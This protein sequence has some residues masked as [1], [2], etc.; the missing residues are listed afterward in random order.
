[1]LIWLYLLLLDLY[2]HLPGTWLY[3]HQNRSWLWAGAM[4][5]IFQLHLWTTSIVE[6]LLICTVRHYVGE[7]LSF[8]YM[9]IGRNLHKTLKGISCRKLMPSKTILN[10]KCSNLLPEKQYAILL[11][12]HI[13]NT[14]LNVCTYGLCSQHMQAISSH[15]EVC[16][17]LHKNAHI[18][19]IQ[20][21]T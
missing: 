18:H 20:M 14:K 16:A 13:H 5:C 9:V 11:I 6:V 10:T 15:Q 8:K 12:A 7:A 19:A 3:L 2:F 17:H 4:F 21:H 1:M